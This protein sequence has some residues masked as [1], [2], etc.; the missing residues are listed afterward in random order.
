MAMVGKSL[1]TKNALK[2]KK[3]VDVPLHLGQV[4]EHPPPSLFGL[5]ALVLRASI[6]LSSCPRCRNPPVVLCLV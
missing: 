4:G 6:G 5:A 1:W 3:V 2:K